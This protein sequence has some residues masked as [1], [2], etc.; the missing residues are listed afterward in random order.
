MASRNAKDAPSS[1][2]GA[3]ESFEQV[4]TRL[5]K[6]VTDLEQG[7]LSLEDALGA[8]EQGIRLSREAAQR[9][10][11]AERRIEALLA[12]GTIETLETENEEIESV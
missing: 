1:A 11:S 5:E 10:D 9:L 3:R 7:D 6:I 12:D 8:F 4:L 2:D